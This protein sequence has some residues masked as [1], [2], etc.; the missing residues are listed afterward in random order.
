[1]YD[2]FDGYDEYGDWDATQCAEG[3]YNAWEE[4]QVFLD[5]VAEREAIAREA[6]REDIAHTV[7]K[8]AGREWPTDTDWAAADIILEKVEGF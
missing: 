2:E 5:G 8:A 6:L 7:A 3:D 4:E 1:M